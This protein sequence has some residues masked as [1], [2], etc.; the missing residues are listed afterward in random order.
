LSQRQTGVFELLL[1]WMMTIKKCVESAHKQQA[2]SSTLPVLQ[3]ELP[4]P[5]GHHPKGLP[6][7]PTQ[8]GTRSP[9]LAS[10]LKRLFGLLEHS[11]KNSV[12][13]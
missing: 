10:S 13:L 4:Q 9:R 2:G 11:P 1:T 12:H 6:L 5:K 7:M 8:N 3:H